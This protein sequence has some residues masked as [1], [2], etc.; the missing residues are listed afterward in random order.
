MTKKNIL[1][2]I[3]NYKHGGIPK[4]L[5]SLLAGIDHNKFNIRLFCINQEEGPY[6]ISLQ[7]YV[8]NR[9]N[10][11]L[12][13]F[14][15]YYTEHCGLVMLW[16]VALK[17]LRKVLIKLTGTDLFYRQLDKEANAL[18]AKHYDVI[19]AYAEGTVTRFVSQ[20]EC[21]KRIAWIHI[22]YKRNL[23]Y[24]QNAD[25]TNIYKRYDHIVIP[26]CF[27]RES[28]KEVFPFLS[29]RAIT[30]PN[31][32]DADS[33]RRMAACGDALDECFTTNGFTLMSVGRICY[34]KQFFKIPEIAS[35]LKKCGHPFRWYIIGG[36]AVEEINFLKEHIRQKTVEDVVILLGAKNNP[37]PYIKQ[38]DLVVCTSLSETFSY[39]IGEAKILGIPVVANDFGSVSEVLDEAHG[40]ICPTDNMA[41]VISR[42]MTDDS[43]YSRL[44]D[45]LKNYSYDNKPVLSKIYSLLGE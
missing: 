30:I 7:K 45:N 36:G 43:A 19:V 35:R 20:I 9:Q 15:T 8:V 6:K 2:C 1:F 11:W 14:S 29:A 22:D 33:I 44:K 4:A 21:R 24:I 34:E 31:L 13:A 28:F 41:S 38:S 18:S 40:I 16:L 25:E 5:E 37:Y 23:K 10:R 26:S 32:L 27:S 39:V 12:W 17:A 42:L 3:E